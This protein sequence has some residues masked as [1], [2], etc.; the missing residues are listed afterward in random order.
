MLAYIAGIW[1]LGSAVG[2]H[3]S[4]RLHIAACIAIG[5]GLTV[6]CCFSKVRSLLHPTL[7]RGLQLTAVALLALSHGASS[8]SSSTLKHE[9]TLHGLVR[10]RGWVV[11]YGRASATRQHYS[12]V[13]IHYA[14]QVSKA[15]KVHRHFKMR[16]YG[17][18]LIPGSEVQFLAQLR[19]RQRYR[20]PSPHGHWFSSNPRFIGILAPDSYVE[21]LKQT[22]RWQR[23]LHRVRQDLAQNLEGYLNGSALEITRALVLGEGYT[24]NPSLRQSLGELG[25]VHLLAVS[26]LHIHCVAF[27]VVTILRLVV[28]WLPY[29]SARWSMQGWINLCSLPCLWAYVLLSGMNPSACR[30]GWMSSIALL[31]SLGYRRIHSRQSIAITLIAMIWLCPEYSIELGFV[32]SF[33]G[34]YALIS[35]LE[36]RPSRRHIALKG[37]HRIAYPSL[38]AQIATLPCVAWVFGQVPL[39]GLISNVIITPWFGLVLVPASFSLSMW[40]S[41][42]APGAASLSWIYNAAINGSVHHIEK[43]A[44]ALPDIKLPPMSNTEGLVLA[45][46]C[47]LLLNARTGR[48]WLGTLLITSA[49]IGVLEWHLTNVEQPEGSLRLTFV[50]VGQGDSTLIDLP[51]GNL[52]LIDAGGTL[53][54]HN[55]PGQR[56][57]L[58]LLRARRRTHI[59]LALITHAHPDH[60]RGLTALI[61]GGIHVRELWLNRQSETEDPQGELS[62]WVR[63]LRLKGTQ[64]R[65]PDTLCGTHARNQVQLK[66]L[67]PCPRANSGYGLNDN[68]LVLMLRYHHQRWLF[69]G[70]IEQAAEAQILARYPTETLRAQVLKVAHHGSKTS[71][72]AAFLDAVKPRIAVISRG[73]NNRFGHPH[74]EVMQRLRQRAIHVLDLA[75]QGG[76]ILSQHKDLIRIETPML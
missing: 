4:G 40:L 44:H 52:M 58:P 67:W 55:D 6:L 63:Q 70:D 32:L 18:E 21:V 46:G 37:L 33:V 11:R 31:G 51:D 19:K 73:A 23:W 61:R 72:T 50:D 9:E 43:F 45:L 13:K 64:V 1:W 76:R 69:T 25:I 47:L 16:L 66:L 29:L 68:S 42:A 38:R 56:A 53:N 7:I 17:S 35:S 60:Y 22:T 75:R 41:C 49:V 27:I 26:G 5:V 15:A 59:D 36:P 20:N 28:R 71:S 48:A 54:G 10:A 39:A 2:T 65:Y 34:T 74:P 57:L 24:L 30:A 62:K 8:A 12:D 3:N 14:I